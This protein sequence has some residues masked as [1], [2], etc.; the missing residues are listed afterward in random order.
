MI[1]LTRFDP[2]SVDGYHVCGYENVTAIRLQLLMMTSYDNYRSRL[3][4]VVME[5]Y[6]VS[7]RQSSNH[8]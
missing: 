7:D 5:M 6:H 8:S 1:G 3:V 2:G 4:G